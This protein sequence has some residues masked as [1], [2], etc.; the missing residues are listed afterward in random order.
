MTIGNLIFG[1]GIDG[2]GTSV[3]SGNIGIGVPTPLAKLHIVAGGAI[4]LGNAAVASGALANTHT[5]TIQD[6][7]GNVYRL[8]CLV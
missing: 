6:S 2:T 3:S 8:L 4:R 7:G 5:L 1:T